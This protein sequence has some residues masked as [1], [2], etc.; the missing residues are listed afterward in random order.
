MKYDSRVYGYVNGKPTYS[1]DE[2]IFAKRGF[3][4]IKSDKELMAFAEKV[5][6][7]WY[8]AGWKHKFTG[9][10]LSEYA[11]AEPY[12][13]LTESEFNRLKEL[14]KIAKSAA[15]EI[16]ASKKWRYVET[17]YWA[18]NSVE[19]IYEDRDGNRKSVM[20]TGPRGDVC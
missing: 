5:T 18:D 2:F 9:F 4:A 16:E 7:G 3:G 13:S 1:R 11:L 19:E 14:Q 15:D 17:I 6:H 20:V 10:Y 12:C 8:D